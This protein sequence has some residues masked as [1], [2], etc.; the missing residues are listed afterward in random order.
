MMLYYD[1]ILLID[2][3]TEIKM[4]ENSKSRITT[5]PKYMEDGTRKF[6][7]IK[8]DHHYNHKAYV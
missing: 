4:F 5:K 8:L 7:N 2:C 1:V 3:E 6:K